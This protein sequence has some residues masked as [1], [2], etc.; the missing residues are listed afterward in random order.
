MSGSLDRLLAAIG[1]PEGE[2]SPVRGVLSLKVDGQT[3]KAMEDAGR[4]LLVYSLGAPE[5]EVCRRLAGYTAG[6]LLK[7]DATLAWDPTAGELI[8]WQGVTASSSADILRR[9]FEVFSASCDWWRS[10]LQEEGSGE[11]IPS[12]MIRP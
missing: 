7:E 6:R 10:R 2:A 1:Y 9:F 8:L 12:M 5:A 3:V 4:L 11:T